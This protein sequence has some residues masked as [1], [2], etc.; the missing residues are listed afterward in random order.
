M[1]LGELTACAHAA[2]AYTDGVRALD[3]EMNNQFMRAQIADLMR[4][5]IETPQALGDI[6]AEGIGLF[7]FVLFQQAKFT[8]AKVGNPDLPSKPAAELWEIGA[9]MPEITEILASA[10]AAMEAAWSGYPVFESS[11][12]ETLSSCFADM[13]AV[14]GYRFQDTTGRDGIWWDRPLQL[15]MLG[16]L[17]A[18]ARPTPP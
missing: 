9:A 5:T 3:C 12:R 18:L 7:W 1:L 16:R 8:G 2:H 15:N 11:L 4:R 6:R 17:E 10:E 13:A 14:C